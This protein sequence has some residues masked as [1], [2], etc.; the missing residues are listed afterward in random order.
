MRI[1]ALDLGTKTGWAL[2][3]PYKSLVSGTQKFD[4]GR[5]EGG[6]MRYLRFRTWLTELNRNSPPDS[7]YFEEVRR[8][9]STDSAHA[10]GGFMA[11]LTA[12]CEDY[13][14]PYA[15]I[16]VGT[17]KKF[18]CGKGNADKKMMIKAAKDLGFAPCD[19]NEA[20]AIHILR[21]ALSQNEKTG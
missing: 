17:I 11:H 21:Y 8:H 7:V 18:A 3:E 20:D 10:Y 19:D 12:W 4:P 9:L 14:I 6:G 5:F 2:G 16:P 1:L 13:K 15:G